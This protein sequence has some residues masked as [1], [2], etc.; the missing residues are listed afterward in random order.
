V[1]YQHAREEPL[2]AGLKEQGGDGR[3]LR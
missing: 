2:P 3:G 1:A